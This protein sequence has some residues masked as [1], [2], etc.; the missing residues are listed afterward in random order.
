MQWQL[1]NGTIELPLATGSA[2]GTLLVPFTGLTNMP[3]IYFQPATNTTA[4]ENST[5]TFSLLATNQAS[6]SYQWR[7]NG[8]NLP[9]ATR[10]C[11]F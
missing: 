3:G 11:W 8:T 7:L 5:V 9:G 1:P 2:A 10:R 6:V 4:I